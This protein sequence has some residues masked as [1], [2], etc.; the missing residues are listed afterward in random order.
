MAKMYA[1][2]ADDA[3]ACRTSFVID[4][5]GLDELARRGAERRRRGPGPNGSPG[6]RQTGSP[7]S[8][9][10]RARPDDPRAARSRTATCARTCCRTSTRCARCSN[11]T[12]SASCSCRWRT[13]CTK[14]IALVGVEWG[15][16]LAFATDVAHLQEELALVRPTMVVAVPRVFEKVF[17][18]AQQQGPRR[19]SRRHLRQV[20]RGGHPL[21][22]ERRRRSDFTRSPASRTL[23]WSGWCTASCRRCSAGGC[24]SPSAAA[25]RS[26]SGSRTSSTVSA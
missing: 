14:I 19:R 7:R 15:I 16:K 21:V 10:R 9:T 4:D 25:P 20:G 5:G 13:R 1:G 11:P 12:R 3:P 22:R 26:V 2:I 24:A 8:S 23:R 18:G 6:S 17:N